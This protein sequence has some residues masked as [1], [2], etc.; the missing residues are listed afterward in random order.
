MA[1]TKNKKTSKAGEAPKSED[2]DKTLQ[3]PTTSITTETTKSPET[4]TIFQTFQGLFN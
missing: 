4:L 1:N 2:P 3:A